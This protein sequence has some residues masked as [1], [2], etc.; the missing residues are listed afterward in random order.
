MAAASADVRQLQQ[1]GRLLLQSADRETKKALTKAVREGGQLVAEKAKTNAQ[2]S[3]SIPPTIKVEVSG[4]TATIRAGSTAD[5]D[6]RPGWLARGWETG[7]TDMG[8]PWRHP[9]WGRRG[10][11]DWHAEGEIQGPRAPRPFLAP[12]LESEREKAA[13]KILQAGTDVAEKLLNGG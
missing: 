11:G 10:R 3:E 8:H 9:S 13:E 7:K 12:A 1:F 2:W 6:G 5:V 4:A